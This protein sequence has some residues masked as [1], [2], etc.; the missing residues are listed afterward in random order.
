MYRLNCKDITEEPKTKRGD[1]KHVDMWYITSAMILRHQDP[2]TGF[3]NA[4]VQQSIFEAHC[5]YKYVL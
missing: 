2:C 1:L 5:I 4:C 3:P